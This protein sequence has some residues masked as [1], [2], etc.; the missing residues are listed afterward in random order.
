MTFD[1]EFQRQLDQLADILNPLQPATPH[2]QLEALRR[3][4]ARSREQHQEQQ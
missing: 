3:D 2:E 1:D 4:Y